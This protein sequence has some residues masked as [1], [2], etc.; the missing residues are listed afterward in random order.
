MRSPARWKDVRFCNRRGQAQAGRR[1]RTAIEALVVKVTLHNYGTL[2][3]CARTRLHSENDAKMSI[4]R[5]AHRLS[6]WQRFGKQQAMSNGYTCSSVH[7]MDLLTA[8]VFDVRC[9]V[10]LYSHQYS[11]TFSFRRNTGFKYCNVMMNKSIHQYYQFLSESENTH[12]VQGGSRYSAAFV[13]SSNFSTIPN[14][15]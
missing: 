15:H 10:F 6:E 11:D 12:S 2:L 3:W 5:N 9:L 1:S 7:V 13:Q 8:L 14:T 4:S